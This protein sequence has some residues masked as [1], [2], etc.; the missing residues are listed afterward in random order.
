[1]G[2]FIMGRGTIASVL[3]FS[4]ARKTVPRTSGSLA[5]GVAGVFADL[6][7]ED[8]SGIA[9]NLRSYFHF[10]F[11]SVVKIVSDV[12]VFGSVG[13]EVGSD[14]SPV[15]TN[16]TSGLAAFC[17][18]EATDDFEAAGCAGKTSAGRNFSVAVSDAGAEVATVLDVL[19]FV[20]SLWIRVIP[21][22]ITIA[23]ATR[24][25]MNAS[26]VSDIL[27]VDVD[28]DASVVTIC[29]R[30]MELCFVRTVT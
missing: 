4:S 12:G 24:T 3:A 2:D 26:F 7:D 11:V 5:V 19:S 23:T 16:W 13:D 30:N 14:F 6:V 10:G 28:T 21:I 9:C 29:G 25:T 17:G 22:T 20:F 27:R 15:A 8:A 18:D 1:M